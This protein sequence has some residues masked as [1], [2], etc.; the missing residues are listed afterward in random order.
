LSGAAADWLT[1]V[2]EFIRRGRPQWFRWSDGAKSLFNATA[3]E[4]SAPRAVQTFRH[5]LAG[6]S[7]QSYDGREHA[8]PPGNACTPEFERYLSGQLEAMRTEAEGKGLDL[9]RMPLQV[10]ADGTMTVPAVRYHEGSKQMIGFVDDPGKP[11]A[12]EDLSSGDAIA[13]KMRLSSKAT[14][15]Y[16]L[17]IGP[18]D[19]RV[20][21]KVI[22]VAGDDGKG[23]AED[24]TALFGAVHTT[25]AKLGFLSI[26]DGLD[27]A[28]AQRKSYDTTCL[29]KPNEELPGGFGVLFGDGSAVVSA[30][31]SEIGGFGDGPT[32]SGTHT[33]HFPCAPYQK[34]PSPLTK[35]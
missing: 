2:D 28:P 34:G 3:S 30:D 11:P 14:Q 1:D 17:M 27:G 10:S 15:A 20:H 32:S 4:S 31:M 23:S 24:L 29:V 26:G 18:L 9:R 16:A 12:A 5:N 6:P 21:S 8:A 19:K 33:Q 35:I 25:V 13:A 7:R 22:L